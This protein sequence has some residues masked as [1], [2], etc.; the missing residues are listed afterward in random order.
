MTRR[1]EAARAEPVLH[2]LAEFRE[3][4]LGCCELL[5]AQTVVEIGCE[6]GY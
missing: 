5:S 6:W 2:S 3:L 4:I 1:G